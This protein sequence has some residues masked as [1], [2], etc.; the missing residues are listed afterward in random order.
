MTNPLEGKL[1]Q[2]QFNPHD[3]YDYDNRSVR[4][5]D[6]FVFRRGNEAVH[7]TLAH[8]HI[9]EL[10]ESNPRHGAEIT[11]G[12]G[13]MN[14]GGQYTLWDR[15]YGR[16]KPATIDSLYATPGAKAD[17][18]TALGVVMNHSMKRFGHLPEPSDNLSKH[19]VPIVH[20]ILD[21]AKEKGVTGT[22][23]MYAPHVPRN[24]IVQDEGKETK[25][26]VNKRYTDDYLKTL[27]H[28]IPQEHIEAGSKAMRGLF[29]GRHLNKGQF[30]QQE[31]PFHE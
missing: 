27:Y 28:D 10:Q 31:L 19:S 26:F 12:H 29:A 18:G 21:A 1:S 13:L 16:S 17:V 30:T 25:E 5:N 2:Q 24:D 14:Y 20:K 4:D 7:V 15:P 6:H 11:F 23:N 8:P 3:N 22:A 9:E